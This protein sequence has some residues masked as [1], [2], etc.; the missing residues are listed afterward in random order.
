MTIVYLLFMMNLLKRRS[1]VGLT[2][3]NLTNHHSVL[4]LNIYQCT[5]V[6]KQE[7]VAV[8]WA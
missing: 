4:G 5:S 1:V 7:Y 2:A 3:T 6:K 8:F